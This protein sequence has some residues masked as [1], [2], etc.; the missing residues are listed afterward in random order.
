MER[1]VT[2]SEIS[3]GKL[4]GDHDLVKAD[5][6][7]CKGCSSCCKGMGTSI[8][9]DP[10]DC[11]RL[12]KDLGMAFEELSKEHIELNVFDGV[13]LPNLKM[14]GED[15]HCTFL[16]Q[17]GRCS[18][19]ASRPGICRIFPLGRYYE[20]HSFQYILQIHECKNKNRTKVKV[21]R[22]IDTPNYKQH[23]EFIIEWHYFIK[24]IQGYMKNAVDFDSS[25]TLTMYLLNQFYIKPY[26]NEETFYQE[27][28]VRIQTIKNALKDIIEFK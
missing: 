10:Y 6:G 5:C 1:N 8:V 12:S 4:Y 19:H 9:L 25:R 21:N 16:D 2:L 15:E 27:F 22:W 24:D 17:N 7:D 14:A 23:N 3:D 13:I 18:I 26:K 11:Y 28:K 20:N